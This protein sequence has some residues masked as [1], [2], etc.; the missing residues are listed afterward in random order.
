MPRDSIFD[1]AERF[2]IG[3]VEIW[4]LEYNYLLGSAGRRRYTLHTIG[5]H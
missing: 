5:P 2:G 4:Y 1:N 3:F